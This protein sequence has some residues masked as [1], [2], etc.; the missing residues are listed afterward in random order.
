MKKF[1]SRRS[2]RKREKIDKITRLPPILPRWRG[3]IGV[4]ERRERKQRNM[5]CWAW[6]KEGKARRND[7]FEGANRAEGGGRGE[8]GSEERERESR[9]REREA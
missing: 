5:G 1:N 3:R 7:R 8:V 6:M 9:E 4:Q 2:E